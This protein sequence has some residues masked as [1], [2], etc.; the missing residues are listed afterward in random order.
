MEA[1]LG[2]RELL[3]LLL[4][5]PPLAA[6][7]LGPA[8]PLQLGQVPPGPGW[9]SGPGS[10]SGRGG[11]SPSPCP[12]L[13]LSLSL[14]SL[15]PRGVSRTLPGRWASPGRLG[16]AGGGSRWRGW[17]KRAESVAP[18]GGGTGTAFPG[19]SAWQPKVYCPCSERLTCCPRAFRSKMC[20]H[21]TKG[22][23]RKL[24]YRGRNAS[25]LP[26]MIRFYRIW[27]AE[28][29]IRQVEGAK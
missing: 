3:L 23:C 28:I 29:S 1:A 4:L 15:P 16:R 20:T 26:L 27:Y 19:C 12:S 13:S 7:L 11:A 5:L 24:G 17:G 14:P 22:V 8:A 9:G 18:E 10:G 2:G 21:G 25:L 6:A